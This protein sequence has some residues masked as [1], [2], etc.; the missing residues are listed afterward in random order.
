MPGCSWKFAV[1]S[2]VVQKI[3]LQ[4]Y[5][6]D[7]RVAKFVNRVL[8]QQIFWALQNSYCGNEDSLSAWH[9]QC[10]LRRPAEMGINGLLPVLKSIT[11]T[12]HVSSY[13]GQ[14]VAV[15]AYCWL[16]KG[17]YSCAREL[18]EGIP[19]DKWDSRLNYAIFF[20]QCDRN[21]WFSSV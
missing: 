18:C 16:H 1:L 17:A 14:R 11:K 20:L 13:Q 15:D 8:A 12:K 5:S 3:C 19:T 4:V 10:R 7:A 21:S 2:I 6:L 9:I